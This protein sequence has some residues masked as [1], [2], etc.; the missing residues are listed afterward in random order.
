MKKELITIFLKNLS[1]EMDNESAIEALSLCNKEYKT[2]PSS[3]TTQDLLDLYD[4]ACE[5][6]VPHG[7]QALGWAMRGALQ[8]NKFFEMMDKRPLTK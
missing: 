8:G 2:N 7:P 6:D 3:Y 4:C 5:Y 1:P